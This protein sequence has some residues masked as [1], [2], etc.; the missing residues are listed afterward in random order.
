MISRI[1]TVYTLLLENGHIIYR[2]EHGEAFTPVTPAQGEGD[3]GGGA[4]T[5]M[6]R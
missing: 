2:I 4:V 6:T 5:A 3:H 1:H